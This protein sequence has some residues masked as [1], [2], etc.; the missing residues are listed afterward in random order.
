M[1]ADTVLHILIGIEFFYTGLL[2]HADVIGVRDV[3]SDSSPL[4][5]K[6]YGENLSVAVGDIL[7]EL[8]VEILTQA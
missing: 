2:I 6:K 1:E 3:F 8:G 7:F 5:I 4:L